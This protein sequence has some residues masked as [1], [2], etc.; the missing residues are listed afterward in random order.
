[1]NPFSNLIEGM[2]FIWPNAIFMAAVFIALM[3]RPERVTNSTALKIGCVLFAI[4]LLTPSLVSLLAAFS[5]QEPPVPRAKSD[6]FMP[7]LAG[8]GQAISFSIAFLCLVWSLLM[9]SERK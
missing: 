5:V 8:L 1:M 6:P 4:S 7:K 9:T 2:T 3:F